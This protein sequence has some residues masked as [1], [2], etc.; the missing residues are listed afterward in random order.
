MNNYTII[1]DSSCDI[2]LKSLNDWGVKYFPLVF[3]FNDEDEEYNNGDLTSKEFYERMRNGE[4]AHTSAAN[5]DTI[6]NVF[7]AELKNGNDIL[8]IAF[9]SGLSTTYNSGRIAA[10]DMREKYP[11]RTIIVVDSLAA[12][13]GMGL[14]VKLAVDKKNEGK[15]LEEVAE[16]VENTK[17]SVCHWFTVD[18]LKYLKRGG[19]V[20]PAVAL[21]GT[22]LNIKPVLHVDDEGHLISM[23][24]VRGR[25]AALKALADKVGELALDTSGTIY[26]SHGDCMDDVDELN[27]ILKQDYNN[28][29]EYIA[30]VGAVIGAHSGP[31]TLAIF[32]LGKER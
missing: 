28:Q 14:L 22:L 26:I 11:E 3:A 29:I 7:N 25:K 30:D 31:G 15:T 12:S 24:K 23:T 8:Y 9:S 4:V 1:T 21:V 16:F 10:E 19:R 18:D 20:S 2:D 27:N 13:A 32:F 5:V 6:S 17:L